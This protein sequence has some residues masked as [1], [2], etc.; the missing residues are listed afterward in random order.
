MTDQIFFIT[1]MPSSRPADYHLGYMSGCVFLDFDNFE[2]DKIRLIRISFDRY[3]CCELEDH[4]IP[5]NV[6]DS[7]IFKNFLIKDDITDQNILLTIVKKV[8]SINKTLI[9]EDALAEYHLI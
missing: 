1:T 6:E 5:L 2:K 7:K 3:G 8:I 9:W 4:S